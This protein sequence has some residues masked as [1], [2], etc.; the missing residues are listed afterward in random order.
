M[1]TD[2]EQQA[3][4]AELAEALTNMAATAAR[5]PRHWTERKAELHR[6]INQMLDDYER[7]PA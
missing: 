2:T 4:R 3:D 7:A 6:Q 1:T 5:V